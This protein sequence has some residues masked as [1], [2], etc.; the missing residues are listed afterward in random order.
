MVYMN[1]SIVYCC[2]INHFETLCLNTTSIY[3][4]HDSLVI[5]LGW[6]AQDIFSAVL[7][8][9]HSR[10]CGQLLILWSV[11]EPDYGKEMGETRQTFLRQVIKVNIISNAMSIA[12]TPDMIQ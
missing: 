5:N 3:L 11:S 4:A 1:V 10:I 9:A 6:T 12:W 7:G 2:V 8:G